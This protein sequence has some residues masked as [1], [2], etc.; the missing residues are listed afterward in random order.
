MRAPFRLPQ[1]GGRELGAVKDALAQ[2]KLQ[3]GPYVAAFEEN[4]R[5]FCGGGAAVAV[6]SG[7]A[8]LHLS[9]LALGIGPESTVALPAL[10][11]HATAMAIEATGAKILPVDVN[12][13]G[14]IK[15]SLI[16]KCDAVCVVHFLGKACPMP[17]I[18]DI[19]VPVVEDC[20]LAFGARRYERHVGLMGAA[21]CFSF[22]AEKHITAAGGGMVLTT[23]ATTM[24]I[25]RL[26]RS[27]GWETYLDEPPDTPIFGLNYRLSEIQAAIGVEQ[28]KRADFLLSKRRL[29]AVM[30]LEALH[31]RAIGAD[32]AVNYVATS[33]S[34]AARIRGRLGAKS[35]ET[36]H[37]YE[38]PVHRLKYFAGKYGFQ[39]GDFPEAERIA[40]CSVTLPVA[41]HI[42][43]RNIDTMITIIRDIDG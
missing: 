7:T 36:A 39:K 5:D 31:P 34:K 37:Y 30:L 17:D 12:P 18:L 10:S 40:S 4:F 33:A 11:S 3:Q 27:N 13:D 23:S 9:W 29:N 42:N 16:P 28:L 43:E 24:K 25:V 6:S 21:G 20:A 38:K 2:S 26:M 8:A 1:I 22:G 35:V 15:A 41:P 19:G 14:N 32:F